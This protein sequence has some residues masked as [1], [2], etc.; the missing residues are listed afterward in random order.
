MR[1]FISVVL[2]LVFLAIL[3]GIGVSIYNAGVSAGLAQAGAVAGGAVA[4]YVYG[5]GFHPG[6]LG[7]GFLGLLFPILFLFLIF[8]LI[9]AAM[10]GGRRGWGHGWQA[11]PGPDAWRS[12]RDRHLADLHRRMH[13]AEGTDPG[14][15]GSAGAGSGGS[16]AAGGAPR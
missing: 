8:G 14:R 7:F 10:F 1:P 16:D 6:F 15:S 12:E 4:P 9:R 5:W 11:G 2:W 3:G 13:E